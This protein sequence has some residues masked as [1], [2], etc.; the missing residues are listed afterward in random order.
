MD[1]KYPVD[2]LAGAFVK[3][4]FA[5]DREIDVNGVRV[6][7][8][9]VLMKLVQRPANAFLDETETSIANSHDYAWIR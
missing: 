9:D 5:D 2:P 8:R 4:G 3:M 7:P 6:V 1:F